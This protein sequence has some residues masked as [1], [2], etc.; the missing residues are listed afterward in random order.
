MSLFIQLTHS[1]GLRSVADVSPVPQGTNEELIVH[2]GRS[3]PATPVPS[4]PPSPQGDHSN[5]HGAPSSLEHHH[6]SQ[7][8]TNLFKH[9]F[10]HNH[11]HHHKDGHSGTSSRDGGAPSPHYQHGKVGF[12]ES[13]AYMLIEE[14]MGHVD[15]LA[16]LADL[17]SSLRTSSLPILH[18]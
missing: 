16:Y 4:R 2:F 15:D 3:Q 13:Q 12:V 10:Q 6:K 17:M 9:L 7:S 18:Q 5:S 8:H 1:A 14:Q 11:P